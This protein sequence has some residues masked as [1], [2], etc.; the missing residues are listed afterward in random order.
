MFCLGFFLLF[1][2]LVYKRFARMD[3]LYAENGMANRY[4]YTKR[5]F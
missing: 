4:K 5:L 1:F 2:R 3:F